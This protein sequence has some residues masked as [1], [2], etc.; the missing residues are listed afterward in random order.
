[1]SRTGDFENGMAM[2]EI[3]F[4]MDRSI[5]QNLMVFFLT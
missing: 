3:E 2:D 5:W 4:E 1:M